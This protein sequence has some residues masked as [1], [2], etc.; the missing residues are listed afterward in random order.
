MKLIDKLANACIVYASCELCLQLKNNSNVTTLLHF[1]F[2]KNQKTFAQAQCS[3]FR[4]DF[5]AQNVLI[6]LL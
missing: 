2:Y 6:V 5:R 3:Y 4:A 1:T